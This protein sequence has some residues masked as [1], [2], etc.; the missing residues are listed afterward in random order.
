MRGWLTGVEIGRGYEIGSD[1]GL[2]EAYDY[3][4]EP[5]AL[6][7]PVQHTLAEA[8]WTVRYGLW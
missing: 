6:K 8:G 5:A 7:R 1:L 4:L 3:R 2:R